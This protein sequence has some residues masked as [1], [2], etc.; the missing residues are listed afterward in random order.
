MYFTRFCV[1]KRILEWFGLEGSLK[2]ISFSTLP[3]A[4][5]P[6]TRPACSKPHPSSPWTLP[7][8]EGA[9][10]EVI[11]AEAAGRMLWIS[12]KGKHHSSP[13]RDD[14]EGSSCLSSL[15]YRVAAAP[16][17][18]LLLLHESLCFVWSSIALIIPEAAEAI[19]GRAFAWRRAAFYLH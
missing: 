14:V 8:R 1:K 7:E 4:G 13:G 12:Q 2:T 18:L 10:Y 6:P 9:C 3:R 15:L 17:S 19:E 16:L 5:R 11:R